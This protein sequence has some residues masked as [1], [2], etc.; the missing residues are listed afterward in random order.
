MTAPKSYSPR[1]MTGLMESMTETLETFTA[2]NDKIV[3]KIRLLAL[4]A[5]IEAARAGDLGR[6][7]AVVASE[8]QKLA[9]QADEIAK[10]FR[11][12]TVKRMQL[13]KEVTA[14]IVDFL[15]GEKLKDVAQGLVQLIVRNLYERT[16]D[17]RWWATDTAFWKALQDGDNESAQRA[18][19]RL[20][21]IK[22]YYSVYL[23]LVLID[24]NGTII[25]NA[26]DAHK[27]IIGRSVA[28]QDVFKRALKT[29]SGHDYVVDTVAPSGLHDKR[30]SIVYA[31]TVREKGEPYGRVIGVLAVYFDWQ[32]QADIIVNEEAALSDKEKQLTSVY[33]LDAEK[34]VIAC[35]DPSEV[36]RKFDL[37]CNGEQAGFYSASDDTVVA[38]AKTIG[39]QEYDGLGWYG[40]LVKKIEKDDDI[41]ALS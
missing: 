9:T 14:S 29:E 35:S 19:Q 38:F 18:G 7:F 3:K 20:R 15:E 22:N 12:K 21:T 5:S 23:D 16:A 36:F 25:A 34:R 32:H 17:V 40:V 24:S 13:G 33:L 2:S 30:Q 10:E 26:A 37:R 39:Y 28:D 8:V 1:A 27:S 6:G 31:A 4:N 11:L 41:H